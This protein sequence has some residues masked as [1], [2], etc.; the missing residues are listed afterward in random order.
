MTG[1]ESSTVD[2]QILGNIV[3]PP[4]WIQGIQSIAKALEVLFGCS[5]HNIHIN[6]LERRSLKAARKASEHDVLDL[7]FI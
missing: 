3:D 4:P 2:L 1:F 6:S 7:V 5:R